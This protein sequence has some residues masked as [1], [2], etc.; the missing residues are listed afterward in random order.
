[1][2]DWRLGRE[3]CSLVMDL[4]QALLSLRPERC[5]WSSVRVLVR[6]RLELR[7]VLRG[8]AFSSSTM[9]GGRASP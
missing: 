4:A 8:P 3:T 2:L 5:R 6:E 7:S 1:M 9:N